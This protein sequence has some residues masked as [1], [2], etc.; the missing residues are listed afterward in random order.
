VLTWQVSDRQGSATLQVTDR[1]GVVARAY[2][3]PYGAPRPSTTTLATDRGWLQKT[4]DTTGLVDLGARYYDPVL[5]RFLSPD[6]LSVQV[7]AQ[8][9][10][11]YAYSNNNPVTYTDPTGLYAVDEDGNAYNGNHQ[12]GQDHRRR[13]TPQ[14]VDHALSEL[15]NEHSRQ[16]ALSHHTDDPNPGLPVLAP[17]EEGIDWGNVFQ[18]V[19][20]VLAAGLVTASACAGSA[21]LACA[22]AGAMGS[23]YV[24]KQFNDADGKE[25]TPTELAVSGTVGAVAAP[26]SVFAGERLVAVFSRGATSVAAESA[27]EVVGVASNAPKITFGHGARHLEGTGLGVEEVESTILQR[28]T[29]AA[30]QATSETGSFWG[31]IE[32]RGT[33]IEYRAYTLPDGTINVGTHYVP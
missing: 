29:T 30:S 6:P 12:I 15:A 5:G 1:T 21:G 11:A 24:T 14:Q 20:A 27:D 2:T 22:A 18:K 10:N 33:T 19:G 7:T 8:S 31:R 13:R 23:M 25:T 9:A 16:V 26:L 4:K 17:V 32:I 3:D 28:V